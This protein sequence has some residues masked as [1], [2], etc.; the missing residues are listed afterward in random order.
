MTDA[1][2]LLET[3]ELS[4][5][6]H[7]GTQALRGV[8]FR[9]GRGEKV[10]LAGPN[11]AGKSTLLLC[12][13]GL[14]RGE[15]NEGH[16]NPP[17]TQQHHNISCHAREGGHPGVVKNQSRHPVLWIPAFCLR[18]EAS[19]RLAPRRA[20]ALAEAVAGMTKLRNN[21]LPLGLVFQNADDQLF[22][23]LVEQDVAFGPR[24]QKKSEE[25]VAA[26]VASSLASVGLAGFEKRSTHH[27]S[28]G[29]KKR[30]AIAATLA[31]QPEILALDEPWANLDA[32]GSR[33]ITAILNAFAGTL[34]V[35]S[36]DLRRARDVC[37]RMILMD[38]GKIV[39]DGPFDTLACDAALMQKHGVEA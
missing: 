31:C 22:C 7:D 10:C 38:E 15:S 34:I 14:L 13:A 8:S 5:R 26:L 17:D 36:H 11:G 30:A 33:A 12:L 23:P 3:C 4:Y 24:N 32:R 28:G 6:Y 2:A 37:A 21:P 39:A 35:S 25:E 16:L 29:E 27:L 18:Q 20:V 19:A 9:I 1:P